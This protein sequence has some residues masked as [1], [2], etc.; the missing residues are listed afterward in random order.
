MKD[1]PNY[2]NWTEEDWD[3]YWNTPMTRWEYYRSIRLVDWV[4]LLSYNFY[5]R[6]KDAIFKRT[7]NRS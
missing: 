4:T 2:E 1:C 7:K 3:K 6:I 5:E